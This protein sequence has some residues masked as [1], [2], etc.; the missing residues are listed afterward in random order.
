MRYSLNGKWRLTSPQN[1]VA[2]QA[3]VPGN[4]ELDLFHHGLEPEPFYGENSKAYR[5]YAC[6]DWL[7]ERTFTTP[8]GYDGHVVLAFDAIDCFAD[9][10]LN[11]EKI[12]S[13]DNAFIPWRFDVTLKPVGEEN[14]LQVFLHSSEK[15]SRTLPDE[16]AAINHMPEAPANL[17]L[18]KPA[19]S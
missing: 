6:H 13:T 11:G 5:K 8:D 1:S 17:W 14:T 2:V 9:I 3:D 18:R 4:I 15:V 12:G 19:H 7:Y 16:F 10:I